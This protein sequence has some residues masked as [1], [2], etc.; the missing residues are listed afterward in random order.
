MLRV[1][2]TL[3]RTP[4]FE[5]NLFALYLAYV[6]GRPTPELRRLVSRHAAQG[7]QPLRNALNLLADSLPEP[8]FL[9]AAGHEPDEVPAPY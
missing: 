6:D 8:I 3:L 7:C 1:V 9:G 2:P 4:A 5:L